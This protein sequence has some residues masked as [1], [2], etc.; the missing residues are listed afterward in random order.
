MK[1]VSGF[2]FLCLQEMAT[3]VPSNYADREVIDEFLKDFRM[4][5]P[6]HGYDSSIA[7]KVIFLRDFNLITM[8][9]SKSQILNSALSRRLDARI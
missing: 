4:Q 8:L 6:I 2:L 1:K 7:K 9:I 5:I 3:G